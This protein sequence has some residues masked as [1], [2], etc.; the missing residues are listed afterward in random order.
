MSVLNCIKDFC[1]WEVY[2]RFK[3]NNQDVVC[4]VIVYENQ[5]LAQ[6]AQRNAVINTN[7]T[8]Y[9]V[10]GGKVEPGETLNAAVHREIKE[11]TN[12]N[13]D[14]IQKLGATRNNKY[15]LHWF[16]CAPTDLSLL[17]VVEPQK[18]KELKWVNLDDASI[19]WTPKNAEALQ[20]YKAQIKEVQQTLIKEN[21]K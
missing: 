18:Q 10:P 16:I 7:D 13:V 11:E 15:K 1:Y 5:I 14:V 19:N 21:V 12:L 20:H 6:T 2:N 3:G 17:K 9:V 4:A 8:Q